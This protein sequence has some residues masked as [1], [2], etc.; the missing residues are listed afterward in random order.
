M[1][2]DIHSNVLVSDTT[3]TFGYLQGMFLSNVSWI[4]HD[5]S[6]P[7]SSGFSSSLPP[8][9]AHVWTVWTEHDILAMNIPI[10][11][12]HAMLIQNMGWLIVS[13]IEKCISYGPINV[14]IRVS[15][16][17]E[18]A[19]EDSSCLSSLQDHSQ[20]AQYFRTDSVFLYLAT[21]ITRI[22]LMEFLTPP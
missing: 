14:Q 4:S 21:P 18:R 5:I 8:S 17:S 12:I 11:S 19:D 6:Q 1:H 7:R 22:V 20:A 13:G 9:L 16:L 2:V 3:L 10:A 15:I